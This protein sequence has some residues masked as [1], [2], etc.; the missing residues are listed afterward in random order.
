MDAMPPSQSWYRHFPEPKVLASNNPVVGTPRICFG[1]Y[2]QFIHAIQPGDLRHIAKAF[3]M[4]YSESVFQGCSEAEAM[5]YF[6]CRCWRIGQHLG[7]DAF[8][9]SAMNCLLVEDFPTAVVALISR[10]GIKHCLGNAGL[11]DRSGLGKWLVDCVAASSIGDDLDMLWDIL[12]SRHGLGKA[13]T[14]KLLECRGIKVEAPSLAARN[15]YQ[16]NNEG[17]DDAQAVA[18]QEHYAGRY[19]TGKVD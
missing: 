2:L 6:Y 5:V 13:I 18:R 10:Y 4:E 19:A 3:Y 7:D 17:D 14:K 12:E 9:N 15:V 11:V 1:I 8:S 16:E